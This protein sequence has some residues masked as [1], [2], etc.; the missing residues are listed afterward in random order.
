MN[1]ITLKKSGRIPKGCYLMNKKA[2]TKL[3]INIINRGPY[4]SY[5][6]F[7]EENQEIEI[8][9]VNILDT[10]SI[11]LTYYDKK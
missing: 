9:S 3:F 11:L 10:G 1:L 8:I 7:I 2:K 4:D 6:R 5:S